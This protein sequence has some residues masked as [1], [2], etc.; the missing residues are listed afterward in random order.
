[1]R[2]C[3]VLALAGVL[4]LSGCASAPSSP[5]KA[6][7]LG[8]GGVTMREDPDLNW[9]WAAPGF[10]L[11]DYDIVYVGETR[12]DVPRLNPDGR[13]NLE[14]AQGVVREAFRK[15]LAE[16]TRLAVV[17]LESEIP[18]SARLLRLESTVIEYEKGGGAARFFAGLYGAG[19]PVIRVQGVVTPHGTPV[20]V[21]ED[22]RSG[23]SGTAR[24]FGGYRSDKAIQEEDIK[25]MAEAL[26]KVLL[27]NGRPVQK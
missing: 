4:L 24:M 14:W 19:Q 13:E 15:A 27:R 21:F 11:L 5:D 9:V 12:A 18:A 17:S 3:L 16:S 26:T 7:R 6:G 20:L 2:H 25:A 8:P 1:M 10:A 23:T 22:K